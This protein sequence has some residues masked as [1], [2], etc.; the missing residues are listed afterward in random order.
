MHKK[1]IVVEKTV[2][3]YK[4]IF[5]LDKEELYI[6]YKAMDEYGNAVGLCSKDFR[7]LFHSLHKIFK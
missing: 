2:K 5:E 3:V 4:E 7:D 6:V 1:T